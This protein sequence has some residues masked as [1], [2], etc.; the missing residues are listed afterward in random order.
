M[1]MKVDYSTFCKVYCICKLQ[2]RYEAAQ[3]HMRE[4]VKEL[5]LE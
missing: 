2:V 3:S 1:L 5:C 4:G